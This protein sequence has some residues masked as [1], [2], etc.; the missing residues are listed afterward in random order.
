M[1]DTPKLRPRM[2]IRGPQ[3]KAR[4]ALLVL[5]V[6]LVLFNVYVNNLA[7]SRDITGITFVQPVGWHYHGDTAVIPQMRRIHFSAAGIADAIAH[8]HGVPLF[9]LTR[10]PADHGALNP[11]LGINVFSHGADLAPQPELLLQ[12]KLDQVQAASNRALEVVEPITALPIAT[13]PGAQVVLS[14]RAGK[15]ANGL[16]RLTVY[17]LV[18]GRLSFTIVASDA[19]SGT[20]TIDKELAAFISSLAVD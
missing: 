10:Y 9:V 20:E 14:A 8:G 13:L 5:V 6:L 11:L 3:A 1:S 18:A 16:N 17:A 15:E 2:H 7:L 4:Y 12:K 19:A